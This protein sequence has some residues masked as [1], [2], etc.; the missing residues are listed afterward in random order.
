MTGIELKVKE[1]EKRTGMKSNNLCWHILQNATESIIDDVESKSLLTKSEFDFI[2]DSHTLGKF[3][4]PEFSAIRSY[5][6]ENL[7]ISGYVINSI[8]VFRK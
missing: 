6:C 3:K 4:N 5:A 8:N 1:F 7:K 2:L